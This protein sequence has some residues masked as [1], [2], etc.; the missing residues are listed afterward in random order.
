MTGGEVEISAIT[1]NDRDVLIPPPQAH[2]SHVAAHEQGTSGQQ[3][4]ESAVPRLSS[5]SSQRV[6]SSPNPALPSNGTSNERTTQVGGHYPTISVNAL[7][8]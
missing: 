4:P 8:P 5:P 3:P 1:P 7:G 2:G 6:S